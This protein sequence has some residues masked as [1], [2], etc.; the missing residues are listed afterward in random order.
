MPNGAWLTKSRFLAGKQCPKRLWQQ[1]HAPLEDGP[2]ASPITRAAHSA[3]RVPIGTWVDPGSNEQRDDAV[4]A[5]AKRAP[6]RGQATA[7]EGS[8]DFLG[9]NGWK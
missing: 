1:C 7:V 2:E 8:C 6:V 5:L 3:R 9:V 4:V